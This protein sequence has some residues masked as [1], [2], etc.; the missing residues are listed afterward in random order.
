MNLTATHAHLDRLRL[1]HLAFDAALDKDFVDIADHFIQSSSVQL[2]WTMVRKMLQNRQE[3]LVKQCIK[4]NTKFESTDAQTKRLIF[5][6]RA[7]IQNEDR[8]IRLVDFIHIMLE[9]KWKSSTIVQVIDGY[10]S[11]SKMSSNDLRE[12]FLLFAMKR[13]IK[14]MSYLINNEDLGFEIRVDNF[15]DIIENSAYDVGVLFYREYFL[16]LNAQ[17]DRIVSLLVNSF[18]E[19]NGMLESKAYLLKRFIKHMKY[20]QAIKFLESIE[21]GVTT[22][23]RGNILIL[24]LNVVKSSCLLIELL[25]RVRDSFGF[26]DRRITEIR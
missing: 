19:T 5:A 24:T 14:L 25:E 22:K 18:S 15:L 11:K 23:S 10:G 9:L 8:T 21:K 1:N 16:H 13:K 17:E 20:E 2:T 26:L 12:L 3:K 7:S 6:G 4:F